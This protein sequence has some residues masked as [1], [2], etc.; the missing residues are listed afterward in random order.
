VALHRIAIYG[1]LE[2]AL[3]TT[4][5]V[6]SAAMEVRD[7]YTAQHEEAV[8]ELAVATAVELGLGRHAQQ[9]VRYAALTHDIG[10]ISVPA[11]IL[12]KPGSLDSAEWEVMRR[13]TITGAHM[14]AGIPFFD[15][16]HP[17]VRG[18]HERFDGGGYPDGLVGEEIPVGARILCVCDSY[19]A[20]ITSRPYRAAMPVGDA[21]DELR[22]G[23]GTQFDPQVVAA[24]ERALNL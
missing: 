19:N 23:S 6:L 14:L 5:S 2:Q 15:E 13:H 8:A 11:E 4:L 9:A 18:H 20:M 17:L 7:P 1:D 16:V 3:G 24:F 22:R 10:K 21:L 12:S